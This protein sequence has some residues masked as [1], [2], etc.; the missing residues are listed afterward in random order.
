MSS[1]E[2]Y[3]AH[4]IPTLHRPR[5]SFNFQAQNNCAK[6]QFRLKY[7]LLNNS[8]LRQVY[9]RHIDFVS[10]Q[11]HQDANIFI[12]QNEKQDQ[13]LDTIRKGDLSNRKNKQQMNL[14]I[15]ASKNIFKLASTGE[16]DSNP[17][18][19]SKFPQLSSHNKVLISRNSI[20]FGPGTYEEAQQYQTAP[21]Q[22]NKQMQQQQHFQD[23][24][25]QILVQHNVP[26]NNNQGPQTTRNISMKKLGVSSSQKQI[27][28]NQNRYNSSGSTIQ[29]LPSSQIGFTN[30]LN[31]QNTGPINTQ[32]AQP[33]VNQSLAQ[34]IAQLNQYNSQQQL[35]VQ[36]AQLQTGRQPSTKNVMSYA[37]Y[38]TN[39]TRAKSSTRVNP[40]S[41][42]QQKPQAHI[43]T[44]KA[45]SR[46]KQRPGAGAESRLENDIS[47][48]R[49]TNNS[50][51]RLHIQ[52][53]YNNSSTSRAHKFT[54]QNNNQNTSLNRSKSR[55]AIKDTSTNQSH[56]IQNISQ[57]Q[58]VKSHSSLHRK[59]T[60]ERNDKNN[61]VGNQ[62]IQKLCQL[63]TRVLIQK[64][65]K[66]HP[67]MYNSHQ[68][69][70]FQHQIKHSQS[71]AVIQTSQAKNN[72]QQY[73]T[74][75]NQ[76][77]KQKPILKISKS[78]Q[79]LQTNQSNPIIQSMQETN[80]SSINAKDLIKSFIKNNSL[81]DL[82]KNT[83]IALEKSRI[84]DL[85]KQ[86][87]LKTVATNTSDSHLR[88]QEQDQQQVNI[89]INQRDNLSPTYNNW[90]QQSQ[91][92]EEESSSAVSSRKQQQSQQQNFQIQNDINILQNS[93]I[94]P[95]S[96][97]S[98]DLIF[99]TM[100]TQQL[101][102]SVDEEEDPS[103][104]YSPSQYDVSGGTS[105]FYRELYKKQLNKYNNLNT[106]SEEEYKSSQAQN[107]IRIENQYMNTDYQRD[108][109]F[110]FLKQLQDTDQKSK[111]SSQ[112]V[113]YL[114]SN[115]PSTAR[116]NSN[117][118]N[119]HLL[120]LSQRQQFTQN[121]NGDLLNSFLTQNSFSAQRFPNIHHAVMNTNIQGYEPVKG[122]REQQNIKVN[123]AHEMIEQNDQQLTQSLQVQLLNSNY[124]Q[125][126]SLA[127]SCSSG[128][129]TLTDSQL[130]QNH[131]LMTPKAMLDKA[132][133]DKLNIDPLLSAQNQNNLNHEF[134]SQGSN[135]PWYQNSYQGSNNGSAG[136]SSF[137]MRKKRML[138]DQVMMMQ[139][140]QT[141]PQIEGVDCQNN[142][143]DTSNFN[144]QG[145][146]TQTT[147]LTSNAASEI[148]FDQLKMSQ[149]QQN[150]M[151]NSQYQSN[152]QQLHFNNFVGS[153]SQN[154][155]S[156]MPQVSM[157]SMQQDQHQYYQDNNHQDE[158][159]FT[160][161][162]QQYLNQQQ[163]NLALS[164][165]QTILLNQQEEERER[166]L[167]MRQRT[168]TLF[169]DNDQHQQNNNW[170]QR[171]ARL[172]RMVID[173][174]QEHENDEY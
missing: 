137:L 33:Q 90:L 97:Q 10:K 87:K 11:E 164:Q 111:V 53:Q 172:P 106:D 80:K 102:Y 14:D 34:K 76:T 79:A 169:D 96:I 82:I 98:P 21:A 95:V 139:Q 62:M 110:L 18:K 119:N 154:N 38:I 55:G 145:R 85:E 113:Y 109:D 133:S 167:R 30:N 25:N 131:N 148:Y 12:N 105:R 73:N 168:S 47:K 67:Q 123:L 156:F 150:S 71:Q 161:T 88:Q 160:Y 112:N 117:K 153:T 124:L 141:S 132:V 54:Y 134:S 39:T 48:S 64:N 15:D 93:N 78:R 118:T 136:S 84:Q 122:V 170:L 99:Q 31:F 3:N 74:I 77:T 103:L 149:L 92:L 171:K 69:N 6:F 116:I 101:N 65:L 173:E 52:R 28:F 23:Q 22:N 16:Y 63:D 81:K 120:Q 60:L 1:R 8:K 32:R 43:T 144:P 29:N 114:N 126:K 66:E 70:Q 89:I 59:S 24:D 9:Y 49:L 155:Q 17:M 26:Y 5:S 35:Q 165:Y 37:K 140:S 36:Q 94:P 138:D 42:I 41:N 44:K 162:Q 61:Q 75:A 158:Q 40:S 129:A 159:Q 27:G 146:P 45:T 100:A 104:Q 86:Q 72:E 127:P 166:I 7:K 130:S 157:Q 125:K 19:K 128:I 51:S 143:A 107:P 115:Q 108:E 56:L 13:I 46:L 174:D 163:Q 91:N 135:Y 68:Q 152:Q 142:Q 2:Q 20:K 83:Q 4:Q 147:T 121:S 57:T 50:Q 151:M 58:N